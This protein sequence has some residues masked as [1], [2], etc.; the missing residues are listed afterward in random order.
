MKVISRK[1]PHY[2]PVVR[3]GLLN[4]QIITKVPTELSYIKR[5]VCSKDVQSQ[6]QW[7]SVIGV[8][9][10]IDLPIYVILGFQQRDRL[11]NQLL[12]NDNFYRPHVKF[13]QFI[14]GIENYPDAGIYINYT[15]TKSNLG[16]SQIVSC[17]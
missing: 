13:A 5:S 6:N 3:Q 8:G 4:Q 1:I 15:E 10:G 12:H 7:N 16:Y 2:T 17:F 11:I 9:E 14:I